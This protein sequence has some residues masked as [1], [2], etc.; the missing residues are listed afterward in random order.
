MIMHRK[1]TNLLKFL[2]H[3]GRART[4]ERFITLE[5]YK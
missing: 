3:V 1:G 5:D 4:T 2:D